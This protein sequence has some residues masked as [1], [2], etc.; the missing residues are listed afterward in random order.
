MTNERKPLTTPYEELERR[1]ELKRT[2]NFVA[3]LRGEVLPPVRSVPNVVDPYAA[4]MPVT[5]QQ[6]V[7][8]EADPITRSRAMIMKVHQV[9]IFLAILTGS[10]MYLYSDEFLFL[11]WI[12][13]ASLEW[14]GVFVFLSV[15][16][17]REQPAAQN[18]M[19]MEG[20]LDMMRNEQ[21]H[22]LRHLYP[23]QYDSKGRRRK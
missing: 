7:K 9:T 14:I 15:Y 3:P 4:A 13:L 1:G 21:G 5:V 18:R 23:D 20:Y 10:L 12:A 2:S 11:L 17:Y 22:R 19:Q 6:V 8:Y 16:D